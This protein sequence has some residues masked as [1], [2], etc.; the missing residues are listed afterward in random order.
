[1]IDYCYS[2]EGTWQQDC[3]GFTHIPPP[4]IQ[5][6]LFDDFVLYLNLRYL[7]LLW[8]ETT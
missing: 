3:G 5:R 8:I 7:Q 6:G 2:S 4:K 1:M